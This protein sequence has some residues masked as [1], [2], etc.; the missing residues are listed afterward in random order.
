MIKKIIAGKLKALTGIHTGSGDSTETTDSPVF[1]N[2]EGEIII[3]G[4]TIAGSLRTLATRIAPHLGFKKC[5]ALDKTPPIESCNC[6][7]CDLFGSINPGK[8]S[9]EG[10][11]S[12]IWIY[13]A[14]LESD[15]K[16]SIRD[17][18][19]IDRET[20][21]SARTAQA[22]YDFETVPKGSVFIFRLALQDSVT[23]DQEKILASILREWTEGRCYIGGNVA[24][25]LG[26]MQLVE[27]K[28]SAIDISSIENLMVFLREDEHSKATIEEKDWLNSKANAAKELIKNSA[29]NAPLYNSFAQ[30]DFNLKL[31]G[32]FVINDIQRAIQSG[33][34]FC[35]KMENSNFILPGSS[36]RGI[37]RFNAEKIA[38]S[39]A[40]LSSESRDDFLTKCPACNPFAD[41]N[42]PLTS[43]NAILHKYISKYRN[44]EIKDEQFCLACQFFGNLYKGSR[45][46][47]SDSYLITS[48]QIKI[49]DFLAIDRFTGG[50]KEGAKFDALVLWQPSFKVR[51]F[52]ENPKEWQLGWLILVL[53][54]LKDGLVSIGFGQNK[55]FGK[56]TIENETIKLGAISDEFI[57]T[58]LKIS[59]SFEGIF[60]I[61]TVEL[62][63]LIDAADKPVEFW[64]R[65]FHKIL[66]D[67]IREDNLAL[68]SDTYFK[69]DIPKLYPKEVKG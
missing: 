54:E 39:L 35:P 43:C 69:D 16:T 3:P 60:N 10:T 49:M 13:D 59:N 9:D 55:W 19:G 64:I 61:Q 24:R 44:G 63:E 52:I 40:T 67:F 6:P 51:I 38:R 62:K 2:I 48:P 25:G 14:I 31:N 26:N 17:G 11:A 42:T 58:G 4:T 66:T 28:V 32:G 50:R 46:L 53:K 7:I 20:R 56:A 68:S 36:L 12:K 65:E 33:F 29:G 34:D 47:V 18:V 45:L 37:L 27:I 57:P 5:I 8:N 41:E 22:K 15:A 1:R 30:I 21:S 23:D